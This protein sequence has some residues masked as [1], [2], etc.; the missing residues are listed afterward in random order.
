ML[1]FLDLPQHLAEWDQ[2]FERPNIDNTFFGRH[3]ENEDIDAAFFSRIS[4]RVSLHMLCT[5]TS[6]SHTV[7]SGI[8]RSTENRYLR[9]MVLIY[10]YMGLRCWNEGF[11][12][13]G[14]T[15]DA[16]QKKKTRANKTENWTR[17]IGRKEFIAAWVG[18]GE[19]RRATRRATGI[20]TGTGQA[21]TAFS[22][23]NIIPERSKDISRYDSLLQHP[24]FYVFLRSR[25][26]AM[27]TVYNKTP[28]SV[29]L[30]TCIH[31]HRVDS[32]NSWILKLNEKR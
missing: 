13:P 5:K 9:S 19:K 17:A 10:V 23:L 28:Y 32:E 11:V 1:V 15:D 16:E 4:P 25:S 18:F 8:R 24:P 12:T 26:A 21:V 29:Y 14:A 22:T 27:C 31:T 3:F 7:E 20:R 30:Y 6:N 2:L